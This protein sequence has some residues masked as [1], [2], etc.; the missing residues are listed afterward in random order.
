MCGWSKDDFDFLIFFRILFLRK[1]Y[2]M[3]LLKLKNHIIKPF[4][5]PH[6][7]KFKDF[8]SLIRHS[9]YFYLL[10]RPQFFVMCGWSKDDFDFLIFF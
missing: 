1:K 2:P 8:F 3:Q 5:H 7:T 10:S 9:C 4:S 6:T